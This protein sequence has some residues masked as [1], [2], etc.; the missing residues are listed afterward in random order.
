MTY[1]RTVV[2]T[3]K[4]QCR[5]CGDIIESTHVHDF[6]PC[7]CGGISVDGGKEYLKR[8]FKD[9]NDIIELSETYDEVVED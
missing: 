6:R 4:A 2:V 9:Y 7:K 3:N 8:C 1:K 5:N